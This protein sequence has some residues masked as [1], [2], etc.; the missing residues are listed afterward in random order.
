MK[1]ISR[2]LCV[3]LVLL[4]AI[5]QLPITSF[6][7]NENVP[8]YE[9]EQTDIESRDGK[10]KYDIVLDKNSE[11]RVWIK[12]YISSASV[13]QEL[14]IPSVID[15]LRVQSVELLL[16]AS[17]LNAIRNATKVVFAENT[18][19]IAG[20]FMRVTKNPQIEL[21]S[22][23]L[24]IDSDAFAN[25]KIASIN[26]PKGLCAIG[27]NAFQRSTFY[28]IT[29]IV[30]PESVEFI[31]DGAFDNTNI[32]SVKIGSRANFSPSRFS[33]TAGAYYESNPQYPCT[34]FSNCSKL[35]KLDIDE[36]NP[37]F[38][39]DN[40]IIYTADEKE[41]VFMNSNP[42]DYAIPESVEYVCSGVFTDKS[43]NSLYIPNSIQNFS[44]IAFCGSIGRL[45][46]AEDC[47]YEVIT[48]NNFKNCKIDELKIPKSITRIDNDAF[49]KCNIKN[50]EFEEGSL[51]SEIGARAF[52]S[53]DIKALDL[54]PCKL[55]TSVQTEAFCGNEELLSVDMTDVPLDELATM[56]FCHCYKLKE[57]RISKYT[58]TIGTEA[59]EYDSELE[60]IDLSNI[61]QVYS[62]AF[63]HCDKI[64]VYDYILSSGT[65]DDGYVFNEFEN[66]V[67]LIGYTGDSIDMVIPDKI[68]GKP[69]T[70]IVWWANRILKD[71]KINSL[72]LPSGLEFISSRAFQYKGVSEINDF[73]KSLRYI[74]EYAFSGCSFKSVKLNEGLEYVLYC[75]FQMC[76]LQ[77]IVIPNSVS[78][79][80]GT[81]N[82]TVRS[83]TI[84]K[85]VRN[86]KDT[87]DSANANKKT[88]KVSIS[89]ENPYYLLERGVLYN[90]DK[91]EIFKYYPYFNILDVMLNYQ[92]PETV[93]KIDAEAFY[94]CKLL[95]DIVIPASVRYIGKYAFRDSSITS[96]RFADGFRTE[97][98]DRCFAHCSKLKTA[99]FGKAEVKNLVYTF[100][101]SALTNIDIPDSVENITGAYEMTD[102]SAVT[103]L[104]LPEGLKILGNWSFGDSY[105]GIKELTIPKGVKSV[106]YSAFSKCSKL[107]NIDFGNVKFLS[108]LAFEGCSSLTSLDLTGITYISEKHWSATF[109]N[110]S[111]LKK[112]TFNRSDKMYDIGESANRGNETIE[113]VV[114]G[115][116]I[117]NINSRAFADCKNL[118]TALISDSVENIADDA[119]ENCD[120]LTIICTTKSNAVLYAKRNNINCKTFK[121]L[122]VPDQKYT[123]EEIK[124]QLHVTVGEYEINQDKDYTVSYADNINP[125]TARAIAA[126]LGDYSIYAS[127]VKFSIIREQQPQEPQQP[128][129]PSHKHKYTAKT[130]K[131]TY[132]KAGYT[133]YTCSCGYSYK[134]NTKAKLTVPKTSISK[135][136]KKKKA[137][138]V[139][140]KKVSV[141]TGYQLQYSTAKS[142][143]TK[144]AVTVRGAKSVS[145]TVSK[146]KGNKTYY[147]RIRAYKAYKGR[148]YY[149]P[150]SSIKSVKTKK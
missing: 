55:L 64:N 40:G 85:N 150:W 99:T 70:D 125:G 41:L 23:L 22:S 48:S 69:V 10:W 56:M 26:F 138:S 50:L 147:I 105:L 79:F 114:I 52:K 102:L 93:R 54:T 60:N 24:M 129:K 124:P 128:Q 143:K 14:V 46:F 139:T 115:N 126:G 43:F 21:P 111:N 13:G 31:G 118:E 123:G 63:R 149:S 28:G 6:A 131:P 19:R 103:E 16:T 82:S 17:V 44:S 4:I 142:F 141:A 11:R 89:S 98:L 66:H 148:N 97:T 107:E 39:T 68:N 88:I 29:D 45:S 61:A 49:Y 12:D 87:L 47:S 20:T 137:F 90:G 117:N 132:E 83:I 94:G 42:S 130:V 122:P 84:G 136:T 5:S 92:I 77:S 73:P 30:L 101:D 144:K 119:F 133:L 67:S 135:L 146:L 86:V 65:T 78:Y 104:N 33:Q 80:S 100:V 140:W 3:M 74:G 134:G 53:N 112:I 127:T 109:Y 95:K 62:L 34:P 35:T 36:N 7:Y 32:T 9:A 96:V 75:A 2:I 59:F 72:K 71:K 51:L 1:R 76:P 15:G 120:H 113:T 58:K 121:I 145:K 106:G 18:E 116:G 81:V 110:C 25:L 37:Y 38:K 8:S 57:F 91:T 108:R 27:N